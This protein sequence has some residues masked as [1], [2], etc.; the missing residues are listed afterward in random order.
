MSTIIKKINNSS[1][2]LALETDLDPVE[3]EALLS[4]LDSKNISVN[5]DI[6]NSAS[7]GYNF[8]DELKAYGEK[9]SDI[10][11]KDRTL[12]GDSVI[13]GK[14]DANIP[15]FFEEIKKY[16]YN[17][18]LIMPIETMKGFQFLKSK[19]SGLIKTYLFHDC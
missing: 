10:H 19:C 11:I 6:G 3:F 15:K 14:G 7:L 18:P 4:K 9:I 17:G 13:L 8:V 2:S 12:G 5:Y 16:N 1:V